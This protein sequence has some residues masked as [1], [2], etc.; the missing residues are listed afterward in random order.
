MPGK[1]GLHQF[2]A[3]DQQIKTLLPPTVLFNRTTFERFLAQYGSV[4]IKPNMEHKGKGIIKAWKKGSVYSFVVVKGGIRR[5]GNAGALY[6]AIRSHTGEKQHV[7]QKTIPL[8]RIGGRP[9]DIRV[10]MIRDASDQ[11]RYC[12]MLAKVAPDGS[13]VTNMSR[14]GRV[15]AMDDVLK[16]AFN[17]NEEE[18]KRFKDQLVLSSQQICRRFDRYKYSYQIGIDFAAD[19]SGRLWLIEVNFDY[20]SHALFSRLKDRTYFKL[21]K[22]T[23]SEYRLARSKRRIKK[24]ND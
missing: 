17:W 16:Q 6:N 12:G 3:K 15:R 5:Y 20:P 1:W 10:M 24:A 22:Q 13:V 8:A 23:V 18:R 7:L 2:Y 21:I 11:W 14:G 4:Y 9:F 19:R